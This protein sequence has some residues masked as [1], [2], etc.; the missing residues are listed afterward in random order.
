MH[1]THAVPEPGRRC[2][3]HRY[4]RSRVLLARLLPRSCWLPVLR[5]SLL[6]LP[7]SE[8]WT[9]V[10]PLICSLSPGALRPG[11]E[12]LTP[13]K[14]YANYIN[15]FVCFGH[16]CGFSFENNSSDRYDENRAADAG[17]GLDLECGTSVLALE[18]T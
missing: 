9:L 2:R 18:W 17:F 5:S 13:N 15:W 11:G 12:I 14:T 10:L 8:E 1:R 4:N 3:G 7:L 6:A 16:I